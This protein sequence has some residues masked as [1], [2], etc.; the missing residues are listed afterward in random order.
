MTNYAEISHGL[1][2]ILKHQRTGNTPKWYVCKWE[3]GKTTPFVLFERS[4]CFVFA[5]E[6]I[7]NT[8]ILDTDYESWALIMHCAEKAKSTRYLSALL[9]SRE[10][11]LGMNVINYLRWEIGF[12]FSF[13]SIQMSGFCFTG[14]NYHSTTSICRSC[15][16]SR[17]IIVKI[18]MNEMYESQTECGDI[19]WWILVIFILRR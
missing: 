15:F 16:Q 1:S 17:K 18:L 2:Q 6:G 13:R 12:C 19:E 5:D 4:F 7:Y 14:R 10:R 11:K 3:R 8:Y 9:L